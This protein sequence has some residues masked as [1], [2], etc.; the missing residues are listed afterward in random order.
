VALQSQP[1]EGTTVRVRLPEAT[2]GA[3]CDTPS[4]AGQPAS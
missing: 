4:A 3:E 2:P 1:G